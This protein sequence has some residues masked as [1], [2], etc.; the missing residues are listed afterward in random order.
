MWLVGCLVH[1]FQIVNTSDFGQDLYWSFLSS[2]PNWTVWLKNKVLNLILGIQVFQLQHFIHVCNNFYFQQLLYQ[3]TLQ[4]VSFCN[5]SI[6][7]CKMFKLNRNM[8]LLSLLFN[9]CTIFF[10]LN[11]IKHCFLTK[12]LKVWYISIK[13]KF[14][15]VTL[16]Q[17]THNNVTICLWYFSLYL[18]SLS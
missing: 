2:K 4:V 11:T 13:S 12:L 15:P 9:F 5:M 17:I 8:K 18:S 3:L 16:N 14:D 6:F 1:F 7:R 10:V